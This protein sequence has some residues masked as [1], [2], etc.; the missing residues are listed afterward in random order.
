[1]LQR[2]SYARL[3][4]RLTDDSVVVRFLR[5]NIPVLRHLLE[6]ETGTQC[7]NIT[8]YS[9]AHFDSLVRSLLQVCIAGS[10]SS[11]YVL[12]PASSS[13]NARTARYSKQTQRQITA[14][15]TRWT[16]RRYFCNPLYRQRSGASTTKAS[17]GNTGCRRK[18][19][20]NDGG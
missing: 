10:R 16:G 12:L 8:I 3:K 15:F 7:S 6:V 4:P 5:P 19:R 2:P 18:E 20:Q 17:A 14:F 1:M 9:I 13:Q 11:G